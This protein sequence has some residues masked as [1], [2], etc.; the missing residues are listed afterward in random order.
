MA[1]ALVRKAIM[2]AGVL[3]A[4][5]LLL[6]IDGGMGNRRAAMPQKW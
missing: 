6:P 2:Y 4:Y 3:L 5:V 1:K